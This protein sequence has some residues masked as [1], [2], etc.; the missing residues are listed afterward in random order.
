MKLP[1]SP[2][3]IDE[4]L[5]EGS[6]LLSGEDIAPYMR[7]VDEIKRKYLSWDEVSLRANLKRWGTPN[8]KLLW[9]LTKMGRIGS[10]KSLPLTDK[11][12]RPFQFLMPDRVMEGLHLVDKYATGEMAT[13]DQG[14]LPPTKQYVVNSI[15]EEAVSS[16]ILEGA[17]TTRKV[18]K[19]MIRTGRRPR[20]T[21]ERMA[22]NNYQ[23]LMKVVEYVRLSPKPDLSLEILHEL[24]RTVAAGT[25]ENEDDLGEFRS[26]DDVVVV[27]RVT[28]DVLH[29]P[30]PA[31]ELPARMKKLIEF[32]NDK[33][34]EGFIHPVIRGMILHFMIGYNHP[35]VDGNGR[36]ARALFYW[37]LLHHDYWAIEYLAISKA[38]LDSPAQYK[39]AYLESE[40]DGGDLTYFLLYHLSMIE[41]AIRQFRLYVAKKRRELRSATSRLKEIPD[42]NHRQIALLDHALRHPEAVYSLGSHATTHGV[43]RMTSRHDLYKLTSVGFLRRRKIGRHVEF[44]VP[45]NLDQLV[46]IGSRK[47]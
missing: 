18:A 34:G 12:S 23:T 46:G 38:I 32:A 25:L 35:Y 41:R 11:Q 10:S 43:T 9:F 3:S 26:T 8:S 2:P 1:G 29:I 14:G 36:I 28:E 13:P 47:L 6:T 33:S 24:H 40:A 4:L 16:S 27:D 45:D 42:L 21:G 30:P 31:K 22:L 44:T 37:C 7:A 5:K 20:N 19:E 15:M 39:R 17:A